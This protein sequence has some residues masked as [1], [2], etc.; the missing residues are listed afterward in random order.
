[1][2]GLHTWLA[3]TLLVAVVLHIAGVA[4]MSWLWKENL[5]AAMLT[6]R[7]RPAAADDTRH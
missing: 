7:K 6:G 1:V 3:D 2:N 4:V 5:P